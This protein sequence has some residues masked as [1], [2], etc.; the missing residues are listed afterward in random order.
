MIQESQHL[1]ET[2]ERRMRQAE[3]LRKLAAKKKA[4][5]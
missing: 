5:K 2:T 3:N 1:R 4:K